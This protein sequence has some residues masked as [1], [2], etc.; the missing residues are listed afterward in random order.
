MI[1]NAYSAYVTPTLVQDHLCE[2][3][4]DMS[5]A[6][7]LF[8]MAG[9]AVTNNSSEPDEFQGFL[10]EAQM[11][12]ATRQSPPMASKAQ[13]DEAPEIPPSRL[14]AGLANEAFRA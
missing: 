9:R 11:A 13:E 6:I 12:A 4:N 14:R 5:E 8:P 3:G 7:Q 10:M 2:R 1:I